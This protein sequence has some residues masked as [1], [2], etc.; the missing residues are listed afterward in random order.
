MIQT[1]RRV[2]QEGREVWSWTCEADVIA[3]ASSFLRELRQINLP[4]VVKPTAMAEV[5]ASR[6]V[7]RRDN[8]SSA[9]RILN[10]RVHVRILRIAT[11]IIRIDP[12]AHHEDFMTAVAGLPALRQVAER[13]VRAGIRPQIAQ[14]QP[15]RL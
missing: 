9:L 1:F 3:F 15:N 14:R 10:R 11:T 13:K 7:D 6:R 2:F 5:S 4:P 8:N 12:I